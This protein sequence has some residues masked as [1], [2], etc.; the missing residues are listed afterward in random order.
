MRR[1][2]ILLLA[3]ITLGLSASGCISYSTYHT[4]APIEEGVTE[5]YATGSLYGIAVDNA[6]ISVPVN[7]I[8]ARYG[9]SPES[10]IGFK[11]HYG[12]VAADYNHAIILEDDFALS[13]NPY[14]NVGWIAGLGVGTVFLNVLADVVRQDDLTLTVGLKPGFIYGLGSIDDDIST[15]TAGAMGFMVGVRLD[16]HPDFSIMPSLDMVSPTTEFGTAWFY[17]AGVAV[18]F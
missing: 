15:S 11:F 9:L 8:G 5:G 12:G 17:N 13:L 7:E 6:S 2:S 3:V 16:I 14:L 4:A 10:D 1:I 18:L